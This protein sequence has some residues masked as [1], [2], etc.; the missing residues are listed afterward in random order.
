MQVHTSVPAAATAGREVGWIQPG[1]IALLLRSGL[2]LVLFSGGL[3]K[4]SQLLDPARQSAILAQYWSP[5]GYVNTFFDQ[6]LFEGALGGLLTPWL[7][8]TTLSAFEL[9]AGGL[10]IAGIF[11]RPVALVWGLLFWSFVAALPVATAAGVDPELSTHR[12]PALL[13]LARDI[14]LSGLFFALFII[15]A[16]RY[17][18]DGRWIGVAATRH[19]LNWDALGLLLRLSVALP[20]L[21]GGA[22]HGFGHI[23]SFGMPAWLLVILAL[24]LLSNV[25]VRAAAVVTALLMGWFIIGNFEL[26]RSLIANM[27]AVKREFAFLAAAIVLSVC[28][29]GRLFSVLAGR[30]GWARL[31]RPGP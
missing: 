27:N 16:G 9:V 31:L 29:G 2:G 25:G 17:S 21:I 28:G 3:S 23:Q 30:S 22:F 26:G 5:L 12:S 7:F 15:G 4:L 20:L 13:V 1:T 24:L 10:L 6:Y 19:T 14:G 18:V 11:V 8:L